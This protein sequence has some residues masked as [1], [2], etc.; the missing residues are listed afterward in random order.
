M[1]KKRVKRSS[2]MSLSELAS[3]CENQLQDSKLMTAVATER[4]RSLNAYNSEPY[5]NEV[6]GLSK[7]VT[8]DVR[9]AIEWTLPQ[10]MDIFYGSDLPVVFVPDSMDD[11]EQAK[12]E[13]AYCKNVLEN[14]NPGFIVVYSWFKDALM[15]K[16]GIVKAW[17]DE[18]EVEE[19]EE[20]KGK[21]QMDF[22][23]LENDPEFEID[24]ITVCLGEDDSYKEF[25]EQEFTDL[26]QSFT[27]PQALATLQQ[28]ARYNIVGFRKRDVSQIKIE[29]I[30]PE[31]FG[32][33]R[34]HNSPDPQCARYCW[35][36]YKKSRSD[37]IEEGYDREL[38]DQLAP[39]YQGF[40][41]FGFENVNRYKK[42]GTSNITV[43]MSLDHA[44]EELLII[45]H[46][47]RVDFDGD[48]IAELR[49]VRTNGPGGE[50]IDN[51]VVDRNIYHSITPYINT[52]KFNGRSL[53]DNLRDL[54]A[55]KTQMVRGALDNF[56]YSIIP[57][58]LVKGSVNMGD[59][60]TYVPGAPIRM[61]AD[62]EVS[63]DTTPFVGDQ[64]IN[65]LAMVDNMRAERT[66]FSRDNVGLNPQAL[67]SSTNLVGSM[68]LS[69]SQLLA[70]MIASIFANT[71][72][73]SL[74]LHIRE[75]SCK[76]EKKERI[77]E[78]AGEFVSTDPRSWR[79]NRHSQVKTG[80]G[81]AAK[82]ERIAGLSQFLELQTSIAQQS[83]SFDSP[84]TSAQGT[85]SLIDDIGKVA[86][87]KDATKY[88]RDPQTYQPPAPQ[89]TLADATF[90]L[91]KEKMA[92]DQTMAEAKSLRDQQ[93]FNQNLEWDRQ[94]FDQQQQW[95][96]EKFDREMMYKYGKDAR[97]GLV[98]VIKTQNEVPKTGKKEN[99]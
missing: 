62:G 13:S 74:M 11:I 23:A 91:T 93:Q 54:Q 94:K 41:D 77:F 14:Q 43:P 16:N 86:G 96:E 65:V 79:K 33:N 98:D 52:H 37:L 48:G 69:Q 84:L 59:L 50:I 63:N 97:D 47:I 67:S 38:V 78:I 36:A 26:L 45:D 95:D 17:W 89:P 2:A 99:K 58:K 22:M 30:P 88:F 27:D 73:N 51:E 29:A 20:Y 71:G 35:E 15:Q 44:S 34:D 70:K 53:A 7:F 46:Y 5:G 85:Y 57:R 76:Y 42:E 82:A 66:G 80:I 19:R 10:L 40:V 24:E 81:Y 28:A 83:G 87:I 6:D 18:K 75:L 8:S 1:A 39:N 92:N 90:K 31:L 56:T 32:V 72:F 9:D 49:M 3:L 55:L 60:M 61:G 4:E 64:A 25:S 12:I 68:I 21:D